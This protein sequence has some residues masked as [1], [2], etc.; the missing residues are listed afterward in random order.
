MA[1]KDLSAPPYQKF[2]HL[3]ASEKDFK[4]GQ[5]Q[6]DFV[7]GTQGY[8]P[9]LEPKILEYSSLLE[10]LYGKKA[11]GL[12]VKPKTLASEKTNYLRRVT[13]PSLAT[14]PEAKAFLDAKLKDLNL[15]TSK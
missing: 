5:I 9:I 14:E 4:L 7:I 15:L 11:S 8:F 3:Q 10:K 6:Y 1:Q 2:D 12:P 13:L